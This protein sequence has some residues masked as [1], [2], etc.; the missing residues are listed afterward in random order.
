M[1]VL[2]EAPAN[3]CCVLAPR[4]GTTLLENRS[5]WWPVR[6]R[7]NKDRVSAYIL[8][9]KYTV[10]VPGPCAQGIIFYFS[11]F[12]F[13][14]ANLQG[15]LSQRDCTLR[16]VTSCDRR[17]SLR[18]DVLIKQRKAKPGRPQVW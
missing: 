7:L 9:Y 5:E 18:L 3:P 1:V 11:F 2:R 10:D 15:R 12:L 8:T 6:G 16:R 17:F 4:G 14:F 13:L